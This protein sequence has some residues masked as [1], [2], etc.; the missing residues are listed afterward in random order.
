[1]TGI[2]CPAKAADVFAC[3]CC[4]RAFNRRH[5]FV[6]MGYGTF[7]VLTCS[8]EVYWLYQEAATV[9]GDSCVA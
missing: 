4:N 7:H 1:M 8:L 2:A 3:V 5:E 9:R 6:L